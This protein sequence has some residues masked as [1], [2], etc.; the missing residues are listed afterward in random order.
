MIY[1]ILFFEDLYIFVAFT[2][3]N[4]D[5]YRGRVRAKKCF[6]LLH[7]FTKMMGQQVHGYYLNA[8]VH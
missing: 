8:N 5:E 2:R 7:H 1:L 3:K 4:E 6:V